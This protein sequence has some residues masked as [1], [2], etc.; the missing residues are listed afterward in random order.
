MGVGR[1]GVGE[2]HLEADLV[3]AND[4]PVLETDLVVEDAAPDVPRDVCTGRLGKV[5]AE[6]RVAPLL[7]DLVHALDDV[8]H[9]AHLTLGVGDLQ[10]GEPDE[11][12]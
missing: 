8:G 4:V 9:P 3:H 6:A 12:A 11:G 1:V 2:I 10:L 5:D 7:P